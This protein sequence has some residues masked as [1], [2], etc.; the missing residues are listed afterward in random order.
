MEH[1]PRRRRP[2]WWT[3]AAAG[4]VVIGAMLSVT[5]YASAD[6]GPDALAD[7]ARIPNDQGPAPECLARPSTVDSPSPAT[8]PDKC[9][10]NM[11][12]PA[13]TD[14]IDIRQVKPA[15]GN[16]VR[17]GRNASTGTFVS[18]CGT[19]KEGHH[20]SDNFIVAPGVTNGAHHVHDY[21]GNVT[22]DGNSTDASL[23]A[24]GTTCRF[25]DKSA[26]YWPVLRRT[27][28]GA[29]P[30]AD[31]NGGGL[32]GNVGQLLEPVAVRL[33]F[34]GNSQSKVRAQPQFIRIITG[35]AKALT[36]GPANA[37]AKW[38]CSGF[39]NRTTTKY[40]VCP[41]GSQ[42]QRVLEFPSCWD[43]QNTD[44]ANHRSHIVFPNPNGK[45]PRRT[46]AVP[47]LTMTISYARQPA[48]TF[49]LDSFP[50]Q[51]HAPITDHGDF[52]NVM[53]QQLMNFVVG[54]INGGRRC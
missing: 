41:Q 31:A 38:T 54:C 12:G 19:N 1:V 43:G 5:Y 35:D 24:G 51:L 52:T 28:R 25:G 49:A 26:Y 46:S 37:R 47:R 33:E 17:T 29:G 4:A 16:G 45:C 27:N 10:A 14:F 9:H 44:S 34:S 42:V 8:V 13:N 39:E 18:V 3:A 53:S 15:G 22:T 21:V 2:R 40:P 7:A 23:A 32:D 11:G 50:E 36:N 30:D 20:N 6:E 48:G